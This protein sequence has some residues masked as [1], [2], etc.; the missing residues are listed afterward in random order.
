MNKHRYRIVFNKTRGMPMAVAESAHS[1]GGAGESDGA[2]APQAGSP[3]RRAAFALSTLALGV[4]LI[5][6]GIGWAPRAAAQIV[7]DRSAPGARQ[8]TVLNT[9]NGVLQVN[10]QTPSAAGVSHNVY[11]RFDVPASGAVLNNSRTGANTQLGGLVPG[12]PWLAGGTARVILNEVNA[13]NPSQLRGYIEVGGE[14]AEVVIANPAGIVCDGCGFIN[15]SR[16]TLTTGTPRLNNG[17]LDGFRVEGGSI[18]VLGAGLD[19]SRSDYTALIARAVELNAGV[20]ARDLRVSTGAAEVSADAASASPVAAAGP[21][22]AFAL[23]VALLGGMYANKITLVGSEAGLGMRSAGNIGAAAGEVQVTFDGRLENSGQIAA[24]G[25]IRL[26]TTGGIANA[27]SLYAAGDASLSTAADIANSGLVA[28]RG[29]LELGA[30]RIDG[31]AASALIAGLLEDG[32]LGAGQIQAAAGTIAVHGQHL[33]RS[34]IRFSADSLSLAGSETAGARLDLVARAGDI[35]ASSARIGIDETLSASAAGTFRSDAA[36]ISAA[37]L[38]FTARN[39]S[40]RAGSLIQTGSTDLAIRLPGRFDNQGGRLASASAALDL[41][42]IAIDNS[43]GRIEHVGGGSF[44]LATPTLNGPRGSLFSAGSLRIGATDVILDGGDTRADS[45]QIDSVRLSNIGG[46]IVQSGS[47]PARVHATALFDNGSGSLVANGRLDLTAGELRNVAG[48]VLATADAGLVVTVDGAAEN[49]GG[50]LVAGG[51]LSFAAATLG[52]VGGSLRAGQ[53]GAVRLGGAVDNTDGTLAAGRRL[54]VDAASLDNRRGLVHSAAGGLGVHVVGALLNPLGEIFAGTDLDLRAGSLVSSGTLY[55]QRDLRIAVADTLSSSGSLAAAGNLSL[56]AYRFAGTA[57]SL[58]GAGLAGEGALT[59]DVR[60]SLVAQGRNQAAGALVFTGRSV[61]VATGET[62]AARI[63]LTASDGDVSTREALVAAPGTVV[64]AATSPARRLDNRGGQISAGQLD[65]GVANLD[66]RAGSLLQT[67]SGD[68]A[69]A[70]GSLDNRGGRIATNS[71]RL[72]LSADTLANTDGLIQHAGSGTADDLL[73]IAATD[74]AGSQGLIVAAGALAIDAQRANLDGAETRAGRIRIDSPVF[75]HRGATLASGGSLSLRAETLLDNDGGRIVSTGAAALQVGEMLNRQGTLQTGATAA[76][77]LAAAGGIDNSSGGAILAG[78]AGRLSAARLDN[79]DG[80]IS[81]DA[82]LDLQ[83]TGTVD[84]RHGLV[85]GTDALNL[86]AGQ[87]DNGTGKLRA[88]AGPFVLESRGAVLNGLGEIGSGGG[89]DARVGSLISS[90]ALYATGSLRI[91]AA[92][93]MDNS[94]TLAGAGDVRLQV[95]RLAG[96]AA[97]LFGAGVQGDG[98]LAG[99]GELV[100]AATDT[101]AAHGRNLAA[102]RLVF[103]GGGSVDLAGATTQGSHIAVIARSGDLVTAGGSVATPGELALSVRG[104]ADRRLDN[105]E[106]SLVA[107]HLSIDAANIDNRFGRIEQSG[108]AATLLALAAPGGV[109]DNR[110]GLIAGN[111]VDFTLAAHTLLNGDGRIAQAGSGVLS[112]SA[113]ALDNPRGALLANGAIRLAADA[114]D[115]RSGAIF[116]NRLDI[117]SGSLLNAAGEILQGGPDVG[118]VKVAGLLD[119]T[120]GRLAAGGDFRVDAGSLLNRGGLVATGG[121]AGLGVTVSGATDNSAAGRIL[122]GG[123]GSLSTGRLDNTDGQLAAGQSLVLRADGGIANLR[124][125]VAAENTLSIGAADL[126]NT[127]GSLQALRGALGLDLG[128][129]LANRRGLVLAGGDLH[130]GA[131]SLDN[132]GTL[133]AGGNAFVVVQGEVANSTFIGANGSLN[134]TAGRLASAAAS[135]LGAG[136]RSDG[137][138]AASGDLNVAAD[139]TLSAVGQNLAGGRL[140]FGGSSVDLSGSRTQAGDIVLYAAAGDILTADARIVTPGTLALSARSDDTRRVDNRRGELLAG[141]LD[142]QA[143]NLD[144][145]EGRLVGSGLAATRL[146]LAAPDGLLDNRSGYIAGNGVDFLL[147]AGRLFN[148]DGRIEHAGAGLLDI[149]A[150]TLDN[151]YGT[152]AGNGSLRLQGRAIANVGGLVAAAG[153]AIDAV[154]FDNRSGGLV[155]GTGRADIVATRLFDNRLGS[156][157]GK[158]DTTLTVGDL[159]NAQGSIQIAGAALNIQ[160]GGRLDNAAGIV[161]A[162]GTLALR[163]ASLSNGGGQLSAGRSLSADIAGA[164]DNANGLIVADGALELAAGGVDNRGG[165]IASTAAGIA[166]VARAGQLDNAGGRLEAADAVS[167]S[168]QGI[169][170]AAGSI[171]GRRIGA[172]SL[173]RAFDNRAGLLAARESLSIASGAFDNA[174]GTIQAGGEL[175]VDTGAQALSNTGSG[176]RAGI[177]GQSRVVLRSALLDNTA[178]F[179]GSTS[180]LLIGAAQLLNRDGAVLSAEK[181]L[182]IDA[183]SLDNRG[184]QIQALGNL[185]I[186]TGIGSIDNTGSL[187]R[188]GSQATLAAGRVINVATQDGSRGIEG[189]SLQIRAAD[190]DN[191]DGALR[192]DESLAIVASGV[193]DNRRGLISAG[194]VLSVRDAATGDARSLSILNTDGTLIAGRL[195]EIDAARLGGDGRLLSLGDIDVRLADDY[196]HTGVFRADGDARLVTAGNLVNRAALEA[197]QTLR[198][199]GRDI[200]NTSEGSIGADTTVVTASGRLTNRGLIDGRETRIDADQLQ[201]MGSGRIYGNHLAI[202]ANTIANDTEAGRS[203]TLAA[204]QRLDLAAQTLVNREHALIFSAG[205]MAIGGTLDN[206]GRAGGMAGR[207][208]NSSATIE[209]LGAL[210]LASAQIAN[211]NAHF[212]TRIASVGSP[213]K[214]RYI[215]PEGNP[216]KYPMSMFAFT[217]WSKAQALIW[218]SSAATAEYGVLGQS[219]VLR[220]G[221]VGCSDSDPGEDCRQTYEIA[222]SKYPASDP[223]WAYFHLTAPDPAPVAPAVVR[224]VTPTLFNPVA[225]DSAR[226]SSCQAGSGYSESACAAYSA[227]LA[228]FNIQQASDAAALAAYAADS[229]AYDAAWAA[230]ANATA[231]WEA[232]T[233]ARYKALDAAIERY[234]DTIDNPLMTRWTQ[235]DV[236]RSLSQSEVVSSDPARIVSGGAM[237]IRGLDLLNDKSQILAGGA[238]SGDLANLRNVDGEGVHVVHE[239]GTAVRTWPKYKGDWKGYSVRRWGDPTPYRPADEITTISLPVAEVRGNAAPAGSGAAIGARATGAVNATTASAGAATSSTRAGAIVEVRAQ[240]AAPTMTETVRV[241]EATTS[242]G[243][244]RVAAP[245]AGAGIARPEPTGL[246]AVA[247]V[248]GAAVADPAEAPALSG[249]KT[250]ALPITPSAAP[251]PVAA[252]AAA[253]A[254]SIPMSPDSA[255]TPRPSPVGSAPAVVIRSVAPDI[256]LPASSLFS[257]NPDAQAR[258][259]VETDPRFTDRRQWLSSD[260]MLGILSVD[261][262]SVQKR[263]GDGFYEQRLVREQVAQLTGRRFLDGYADDEAQYL[264]LLGNAA[265]YARAWNL[266]PGVALSAEQMARL[267]SDIV[268]LV[269]EAIALPDGRLTHALVPRLYVR[270]REGDLDGGGTL[271]SAD[272]LD[273]ALSGDLENSGT[274]AGRSVVSLSAENVRNLGGRIRGADVAVAARQDVAV[275]GGRVEAT[276]RL[277][278]LAGRDLS[279]ASTTR[280]SATAQGSYTGIDRIAGL[281]ITGNTAAGELVAAAGRDL[282]LTAATVKNAG[283][284]ATV[285]SAGRDLTLATV[286]TARNQ[287]TVWDSANYRKD[288]TRQETGTTLDTGGKLLL[289]SGQDLTARAATLKAQGDLAL[290][291]GNDLT[292]ETGQKTAAFDE[293]QRITSNDLFSRKTSITRNAVSRQSAV[294][295]TLDGANIDLAAGRDIRTEAAQLVAQQVLALDAGRDIRIGAAT[296]SVSETHLNQTL[297]QATGL[298]KFV[299]TQ[300]E[301]GPS[302]LGIQAGADIRGSQQASQA[303]T[304]SSAQAVGST[305]SG[306]AIQTRSGRDMVVQGSTAVA[307]GDIRIETGRDLQV[308]AALGSSEST[309][310]SSASKNGSLGKPWQPAIGHVASNGSLAETSTTLTGSQVASLAGSVD[311]R[312]GQTYTQSASDV[313]ALG[314]QPGS[315]NVSIRA[316]EVAIDSAATTR[317]STIHDEAHRAALGGTVSVP[318]VN[319]IRGATATVEAAGRTR[320]SRSQALAAAT[321]ALQTVAVASAVSNPT[322]VKVGVSLGSSNNTSDVVQHSADA[323]GSKIAATGDIVIEASGKGETSRIQAT[324]ARIEAGGDLNLKADGGVSLEAASSRYTQSSTNSSGGASIGVAYSFGGSQ[325]G[326]TLEIGANKNQGKG[327]GHDLQHTQ[328]R[329]IAGETVRLDIGGDTTLRGA[330][331]AGKQIEA[332][333][334]GGLTVESVQDASTFHS[335]QHS[336]GFGLSLCIPPFCYGTSTASASAGQNRIDSDFLSVTEQSGLFAGDRGFQVKVKGNTDLTG[337]VIASTAQANLNWLYTDSLATKTIV[338]HSESKVSSRGISLDTSMLTQGKYGLTKGL[339]GNALSNV[340]D[341]ESADGQTRSGISNGEIRINND[342]AQYAQTGQG[343]EETISRLNR[344]TANAHAAVKKQDV[345]AIE[346]T[347]EANLSIKR[348]A[349]RVVTA[350]ADEAYRSRFVQEPQLIKVVCPVES[351]KCTSDPSLVVRIPASKEE[352]A[353]AP[354]GTIFAVNGILNDEKRGAELAYQNTKPERQNGSKPSTV[355]L[356]HIAPANNITSELIGVAYEK[357]TATSGYDLANFLGY[358]KGQELYS[359]VLRSRDQLATASLGHSRGTLIQ[360]AAFVMLSNRQEGGKTYTNPK[361]S[362]RGVGG[363]ADAGAYFERAMQVLGPQG[364][365]QNITYSYFSNDPVSTSNLSGGNMGAWTVSDL[366]RVMKTNNSMHSCYGTGGH[367]CTQVEIPVSSGPQGTS[368]GNNKLV[369]YVG[370]VRLER[371]IVSRPVGNRP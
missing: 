356:M 303:G 348:D 228:T 326:F 350:L 250:I 252:A 261:P 260:Y 238:L 45:L 98:S 6:G 117:R 193:L 106:G 54:D 317:D 304:Q 273:I 324:G 337:A 253:S 188:A 262:A 278:V 5:A 359:D 239:E 26:N 56:S 118:A 179:I 312:V 148:T 130:A 146:V 141:H 168:A 165:Q 255:A 215:Q 321:L 368:V 366:W 170:N 352:V 159:L 19:A 229:A 311:I 59:L 283:T 227:E 333:I 236:T 271:I 2:A 131:G 274:L 14:R 313:L 156:V 125:L 254:P 225:P 257:V 346:R 108:T 11:S 360:E 142:I 129:E 332:D 334:R 187:I 208:D 79:R 176:S 77:A 30:A 286:A 353:T 281:Y 53:D 327:D 101:L 7:A 295:T 4:L 224:P 80:T 291:A 361:L 325:N 39:L 292:L 272:T 182:G 161:R 115:N 36:Q 341:S 18:A 204:R 209:A 364:E 177:F 137:S 75:T 25:L 268:W 340:S 338:N 293:A 43:E 10:I 116:A 206:S 163:A 290:H 153:L 213:E 73:S 347:V 103:D 89:F 307:D 240:A 29:N 84:N 12:N 68:T 302:T 96:S 322:G 211:S 164:A 122:A 331:I 60:D 174:A 212:S 280:S 74:L 310:T 3:A 369:E 226:A 152:L 135:L 86:A 76:L 42:A 370:G 297:R 210:S 114:L 245:Q 371:E 23:D 232:T 119:N 1:H 123:L 88:L 127:D 241:A 67:G 55:S 216:G 287:A 65:L 132:S 320:D 180:D 217:K 237:N 112:L 58:L 200:D 105:R 113:S 150:D 175:R 178:G 160:A 32:S 284:G 282:S 343:S 242:V 196:L 157:A 102:G 172:D 52:N 192:A 214:I 72:T 230:H 94:G 78:G 66:N 91:Q 294:S 145:R 16:G 139:G 149:R 38:D 169:V 207:I 305:L 201:N 299:G 234:N 41:A 144:N 151:S 138:L 203:A 17:S 323:V 285:V 143:A 344:D 104:A 22:P 276:D 13:S 110:N 233:E 270:V 111:G 173:G 351:A 354:A 107:G 358:T 247:G 48:K 124:G 264:A 318:I 314:T 158:G 256:R 35:D 195:L 40:N 263:L 87:V 218:V 51:D 21:V 315:A 83:T 128:G 329:L 134:L 362:V 367:G 167:L 219:P 181:S 357:I 202:G 189:R 133:Y 191:R 251:A 265:T 64:I 330:S 81:A 319:A 8:A 34:A 190:I 355:Y 266:I 296:E 97:S 184:G 82:A 267:T 24:A 316:A 349:I 365:K 309:S 93:L 85:V 171:A 95:G 186:D 28:A 15:A 300:L 166:V 222:A 205:D 33:A 27:G 289:E 345:D 235:Y 335:E 336:A 249:I 275:E 61:D 140:A 328:T 63:A 185:A 62:R 248:G 9:A 306:A 154:D 197:G 46:Q 244:V 20:W 126:D 155:G 37:R 198:L 342:A 199:A 120:G 147:G 258:Y 50:S 269:D 220:V 44:S 243:S 136:I 221:E 57:G 279:V 31:S 298:G 162:A 308:V 99:S 92:G 90:G 183:A 47:G 277:A 121:S 288:A 71:R 194:T 100:V 259:I 246:E 223:A 49:R 109:L 301:L 339:I 231:T 363:A 70:T 69:I